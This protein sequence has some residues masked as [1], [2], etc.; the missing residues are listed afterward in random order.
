MSIE[1]TTIEFRLHEPSRQSSDPTVRL[2]QAGRLPRITQLLGL[3]LSLRERIRSGEVSSYA[4]LAREAMVTPERMSQVMQLIWLA[5][6]IQQAILELPPGPRRHPVTEQAMRTIAQ[7]LR[8]ADQR[9][10]W[11]RLL[12]NKDQFGL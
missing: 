11:L 8:W 5:P 3:A 9:R 10:A 1:P 6:E 7:Q 12:E 2:A 4:Q